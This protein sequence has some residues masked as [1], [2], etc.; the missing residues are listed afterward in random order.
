MTTPNPPSDHHYIP[1]FILQQWTNPSTARL[2]RYT[3]PH[4]SKIMRRESVTSAAGFEENLYKI[5]GLPEDKAQ[6]LETGFFSKIDDKAAKVHKLLLEGRLGELSDDQ[7]IAWAGFVMVLMFRTPA[8]LTAF[9]QGFKGA[10]SQPLPDVDARYS[11]LKGSDDPPTYEEYVLKHDPLIL[12]RMAMTEF[13]GLVLN[14]MMG[15]HLLRMHWFVMKPREGAFLISD[16][17]VIMKTGLAKPLGHIVVPIGPKALFVATVDLPTQNVIA[18]MGCKAIVREVNKQVVGRAS[19]FVAAQ[20]ERQDRFIRNRFATIEAVS[21]AT[22][23]A[24]EYARYGIV[25][26][27]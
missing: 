18:R 24:D 2:Q 14:E 7:K 15:A 13:P 1:Q 21:I 9:K 26:E 5:P 22:L 16:E 25:R 8:N 23:F 19:C 27:R 20:D 17:P 4:A 11:E 12:D 6:L 3:R 10:W